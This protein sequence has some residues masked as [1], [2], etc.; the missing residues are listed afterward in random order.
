[1]DT[2]AHLEETSDGSIFMLVN[3]ALGRPGH[4]HI[5]KSDN[6]LPEPI[7]TATVAKDGTIWV[8]A[9]AGLY[10]FMYPFQVELWEQ[11]SIG[12]PASLVS[13]GK[14]MFVT[15][16]GIWRLN[17]DRTKWDLLPGTKGFGGDC[18]GGCAQH[19]LCR[20]P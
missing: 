4:F 13:T 15:S 10:R 12:A 2:S 6:G 7:D 5:A 8:G 16:G 19:A 14:D 1:M 3:L 9:D 18:N 17:E 20:R 11:P